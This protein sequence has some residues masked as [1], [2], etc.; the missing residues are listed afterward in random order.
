MKRTI[1]AALAL[2]FC[3]G[4]VAQPAVAQPKM[5]GPDFKVTLLGTGTPHPTMK[6]FGPSILVQ[7]GG[8]TL[9]FDCGRGITQRLFQ[10]KMP[11]GKVDHVFLTHLHSDH[12]IG[13]P[14]LWLTGW[15]GAPFARRKGPFRITGPEGTAAMMANLEKAFAWDIK[16]R[17]ED[18]R[19]PLENVAVAATDMK[20]GVVYDEGGLKVSAVKV[21]HGD[22]IDLAYG[23]RVEYGG[24]AVMMSGDTRYT[25]ALVAAAKGADLIIHSVAAISPA[26][27]K[28]SKVMRAILSHHSEPEDTARVFNAVK[29][30]LAVY[31]HIVTYGQKDADIMTRVK[32]KYDGDV[33]MGRDLMAIA[34]GKDGVKVLN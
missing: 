18:Q 20:G 31:S 8:K 13:I 3:G 26:L 28:K 19:L 12:V 7:A 22:K 25:E 29:P 15:L 4:L 34:V 9:L 32:A 14:D 2:L 21:N 16:T 23:Y 1:L 33:R 24:R 30:K 17:H 27:L 6:R 11:F 10:V 5:E